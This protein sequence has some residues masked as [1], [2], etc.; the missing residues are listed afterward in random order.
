MKEYGTGR[1]G[2]QCRHQRTH[3]QNPAE[4]AEN[5]GRDYIETSLGGWLQMEAVKQKSP[6]V[7][8]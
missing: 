4:A 1:S 8:G 2:R 7:P 3:Q 6:F 5:Y